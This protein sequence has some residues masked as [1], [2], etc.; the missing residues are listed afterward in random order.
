MPVHRVQTLDWDVLRTSYVLII[1][2]YSYLMNSGENFLFK[3]SFSP[4]YTM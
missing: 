4:M 3:H 2:A 1:A